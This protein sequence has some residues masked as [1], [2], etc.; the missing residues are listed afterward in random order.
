MKIKPTKGYLLIKPEE[1]ETTTSS[2][3]I[4]STKTKNEA[5]Q[6]GTV[7]VTGPGTDPI[8]VKDIVYFKKWGGND[9]KIDN[10]DYIFV[11]IED[12]LGVELKGGVLKSE[13]LKIGR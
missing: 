4:I 13:N 9:I 10:I 8:K 5:P 11:K 12:V 3:I 6:K 1:A 7:I 2:G